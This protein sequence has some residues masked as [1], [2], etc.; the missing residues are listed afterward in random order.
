MSEQPFLFSDSTWIEVRDGNETALSLF[1]RHYTARESRKIRQFVGPGEKCVLMTEDAC[2]LFVWRKFRSDAGQTG[3]NCAVFRTEGSTAGRASD[4]IR[5]ADRIGWQRWPGER[6]YT[7]VD[8]RKVRHKR[9]PGRCFLKA[10]WRLCG[11]SKKRRLLIFEILPTS[12]PIPTV[13]PDALQ[14][15]PE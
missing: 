11:V 2:A 10:G 9:D 1:L 3:I 8:P 13:S 15:Q 6:H 14:D 7:Y 5:E 4:L 12:A